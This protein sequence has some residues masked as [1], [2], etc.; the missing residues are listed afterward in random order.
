MT[1]RKTL[2]KVLSS[3][4][5]QSLPYFAAQLITSLGQLAQLP[6]C[7]LSELVSTLG[8]DGK[9]FPMDTIGTLMHWYDTL[10]M[11]EKEKFWILIVDFY[12]PPTQH[13]TPSHGLN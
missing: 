8:K 11:S 10:S 1:R 7:P 9:E 4:T 3:M 6:R 2:P 5:E 13:G 12:M